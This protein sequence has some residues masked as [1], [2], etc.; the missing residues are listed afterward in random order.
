MAAVHAIAV[1]A[2]PT[3]PVIALGVWWNAN[4][5]SHN[6]IHRPFFR[7]RWLNRTFAL[8]M[9]VLLGI[10]QS[11]W[12]DLHLAHHAGRGWRFRRSGETAIEIVSILL[13]WT[14]LAVVKPHF[15]MLVYL[16]GYALGL[17]LCWCQGYHE[18]A[19]GVTSHYGAIYNVLCFNDGYHA[20]HHARP[21][22]HWTELARVP[23][24]GAMTSRWPPL[25]RWI[26]YLNLAYLNLAYLNLA[27]LNLAYLNLEGLESLVLRSS[28]LQRLVIR[29]HAHAI[30]KLLPELR[31]GARVTIVGGGLFPRTALILREFLPEARITVLDSNQRH[32]EIA[33]TFFTNGS[34]FADRLEFLER[35]Y[36]CG[37]PAGCDL[38]VIPLSFNGDRAELYSHPPAPAVLIHDW[39]WRRRGKSTV[40]S[41]LLLKR[42]NL[43]QA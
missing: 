12:R 11:L 42:I 2:W 23:A 16:P 22:R 15:F 26:D 40:V 31:P 27:Y 4:T 33:R 24:A 13:L 37:D 35:T 39:I 43:I 18:H 8:Y 34:F 3:I 9:S 29:C 32:L 36:A 7:P 38:L 28:G 30:G 1:I 17:A 10:P 20:E 41:P 14:A 25:L 19:A 21:G 6:F 5:I